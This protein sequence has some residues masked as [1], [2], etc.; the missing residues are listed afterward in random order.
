M[1]FAVAPAVIP[2]FFYAVYLPFIA[3]ITGGAPYFTVY[4]FLSV[5]L[6]HYSI[7]LAYILSYPAIE[8]VSPTLAIS[9]LVGKAGADGLEYDDILLTFGDDFLL[10]PRIQDL[11]DAGLAEK[12]GNYISITNRGKRLAWCFIQIRRLLGLPAG[13]G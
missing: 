10:K 7:S 8:A 2:V 12:T 3:P 11:L 4:E 9:L 6:L 13:K 5:Y 1:T